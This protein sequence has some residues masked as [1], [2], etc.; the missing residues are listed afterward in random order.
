[1]IVETKRDEFSVFKSFRN[2]FFGENLYFSLVPENPS[3]VTCTLAP[4]S[5][6]NQNKTSPGVPWGDSGSWIYPSNLYIQTFYI[7]LQPTSPK[8]QEIRQKSFKTG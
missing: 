5:L 1:M 4:L 2:A 3:C 6:D 7:Y 8:Y